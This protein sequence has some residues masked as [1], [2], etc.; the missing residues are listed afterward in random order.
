MKV[1]LWDEAESLSVPSDFK[2]LPPR[3]TGSAEATDL[4]FEAALLSPGIDPAHPFWRALRQRGIPLWGELE[5]V[6]RQINMPLIAVT[7]TNGKSTTVS[8]IA[9]ILRE[10]G[11]RVGLKGNIGE[12]LVEVLQEDPYDFL[13]LEAS[14]YQLETTVSLAP[15]R[16][17]WL[18]LTEDHLKR[19]KTMEAYAAAKAL[20]ALRQEPEHYFF[21]NHDD[22]WIVS[23]LSKIRSGKV[24]WTLS[25]TLKE[26]AYWMN[27][28]VR[29]NLP[30]WGEHT[31]HVGDHK[32]KGY[33]HAENILAA[34]LVSLSLGV[35]V[36]TIEK[37]VLSFQ[38]LPHRLVWLGRIGGADIYNDS[39]A[40]NVS[41]VASSLA[42]F[43]GNVHLMLGGADKGGE[44]RSLTEL[45]RAKTC[46]LW[47]FGDAG[48]R[49]CEELGHV[50]PYQIFRTLRE[51]TAAAVHDLAP[52]QTLLLAPGCASFDEFRDF[53]H[54][55]E[56][57]TDWITPYLE[58]RR[59]E[60]S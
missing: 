39:K 27:N 10:A 23:Y 56:A 14:S 31:L 11:Y 55:G 41:A 6:S 9:H 38:G 51:A 22:P 35:S 44:L 1:W 5:W 43:Q 7:G 53:N 26:G 36:S 60:G 18:N 21:Y 48:P 12:P 47:F 32:L 3:Y 33:G 4:P 50:K 34:I 19:H 57:F 25:G 16:A 17:V 52:G 28:E 37:A 46:K 2:E 59:G 49:F 42:S 40:T 15:H 45:I 20:I 54:R 8:L 13:V 58:P 30:Q 24:G 29:V